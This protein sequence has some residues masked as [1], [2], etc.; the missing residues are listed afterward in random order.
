MTKASNN[1]MDNKNLDIQNASLDL[2]LDS[3]NLSDNQTK[4]SES[5]I[6]PKLSQNSKSYARNR[7]NN[8]NTASF[9]QARSENKNRKPTK[10][11]DYSG[12]NAEN[13][14][15][16]KKLSIEND[17]FFVIKSFSAQDVYNSISYKI[18]CSTENGNQKLNNAFKET[19]V[20]NGSVYLFFSVNGSG[21]FCGVAKMISEVDF[22]WQPDAHL[23]SHSTKVFI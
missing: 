1:E 6:K 3:I 15:L 11:I 7:N 8:N 18:W 20:A 19:K 9:Y 5:N 17:K 2:S 23:W 13:F 16:E 22:S 21:Y 10:I 14:D 4:T 12:I